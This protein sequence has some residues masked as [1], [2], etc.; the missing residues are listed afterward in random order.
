MGFLSALDPWL[1]RVPLAGACAG[2]WL[3]SSFALTH[4][5]PWALPCC[6]LGIAGFLVVRRPAAQLVALVVLSLGT[7]GLGTRLSLTD[8]RCPA[9]GNKQQAVARLLRMTP[10]NDGRTSLEV[11]LEAA[12]GDG[13]TGEPSAMHCHALLSAGRRPTPAGEGDTIWI[14]AVDW[15]PVAHLYNPGADTADALE[16]RSIDRVASIPDGAGILPLA[17]GEPL[18]RAIGRL[19]MRVRAQI[20][21]LPAS[22]GRE[23][24]HA[25]LLGE[26]SIL[27]ASIMD[28]FLDS[29]LRHFLTDGTLYLAVALALSLSMLRA[30]VGRLTP[31]IARWPARRLAAGLCL[32][33]PMIYAKLTGDWPA[34]SRASAMAT[35]WLL[36]SALGR[37]RPPALHLVT[38]A[39]VVLLA[40]SPAEARDPGLLLSMSSLLLIAA[41]AGP[42]AARL[43]S[44]GAR[45]AQG[46]W[47]AMSAGLAVALAIWLATLPVMA[48]ENQRLAYLGLPM[49]LLGLPLG[50]GMAAFGTLF[51]AVKS[52]AISDW[53]ALFPLLASLDCAKGLA[54]LASLAAPYSRWIIARPSAVALTAFFCGIAGLVTAARHRRASLLVLGPGIAL[55]SMSLALAH[56]LTPA[57]GSL[58]LT[59]LSVGQGDG[60]VIELPTGQTLVLD[61]GGSAVGAFDPGERVVAPFLWSHGIT[62]LAALVLSHPHPDH[63]NGLPY[64]LSRFE[65][66]ELWQS[67]EPCGLA[68]C[69]EM[70]RLAL[71][72]GLAR[73]RLGS[74][75]FRFEFGP[76]ALTL[77]WPSAPLGYDP[78]LGEND[79]SLVFRLTFGDFSAL[80]PGDIEADAERAL[81]ASG[82]ALE[83]DVLKAPHHG[84]DTSSTQGF[85]DRVRPRDVVFSVGPR[86]RFGFP[87]A[88]VVARYAAAGASLWRTDLDGAVTITTNG[89]GGYR[90]EAAGPARSVEVR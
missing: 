61:A 39:V 21:D 12:I 14:P 59:F 79:N 52:L 55:V 80:L 15:E 20:D 77:L 51:I 24:L 32:P 84:S 4:P 90:L 86:N 6:A 2:M 62:R 65:V 63:A 66:G 78:E 5:A 45:R 58:R 67:G 44:R 28:S 85:V 19:R 56:A 33:V 69:D 41:L 31:I 42:L 37:G 74:G 64:L 40:L 47:A 27:S 38:C 30:A 1:R 46:L 3:A 81:I 50:A 36:A 71:S 57:G 60:L 13:A 34:A 7:G 8:I 17:N 68:A 29:G 16:A 18:G 49:S 43:Q 76:V 83:A 54:A 25:V 9:P 82:A 89:K 10:E 48:F 22:T 26:R 53:V 87:R 73:R 23:V 72:K 11:L 70:E 75:P 35:V 88:S